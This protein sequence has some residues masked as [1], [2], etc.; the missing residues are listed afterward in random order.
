MPSRHTVTSTFWPTLPARI[1]SCTS[2]E[3]STFLPLTAV[4]TSPGLAPAFSAGE[5]AMTLATSAP[6]SGALLPSVLDISGVSGC[7]W[8][9]MYGRRTCPVWIS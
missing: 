2:R 5:P 1:R 8:M 7:I 3:S 9:P 6:L 4:M